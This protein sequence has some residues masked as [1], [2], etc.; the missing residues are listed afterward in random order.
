MKI[1]LIDAILREVLYWS[2][3]QYKVI[4]F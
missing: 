3:Y 1:D 2:M 4:D